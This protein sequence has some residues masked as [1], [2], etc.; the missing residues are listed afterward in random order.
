MENAEEELVKARTPLYKEFEVDG[1]VLVY[2]FTALRMAQMKTAEAIYTYQA[3]L[4]KRPARTMKEKLELS[5]DY[6]QQVL[7][8]ILLLKL[9]DGSLQKYQGGVTQQP[10]LK[11]VND[12]PAKYVRDLEDVVMDFFTER[13]KYTLALLVQRKY[14]V[15]YMQGVVSKIQEMIPK[16]PSDESLESGPSVSEPSTAPENPSEE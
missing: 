16:I 9:P 7:S 2:D 10:I 14:E 3:D 15:Q 1:K 5:G 13:D 4:E 12:M 11:L 6:D 8:H